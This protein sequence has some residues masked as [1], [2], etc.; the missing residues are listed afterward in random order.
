MTFESGGIIGLAFRVRD[1]AVMD[2]TS[3]GFENQK[4]CIGKIYIYGLKHQREKPSTEMK[5]LTLILERFGHGVGRLNKS[6]NGEFGH[7]RSI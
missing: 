1:M 3:S 4:V 7:R 2:F 6:S 5:G